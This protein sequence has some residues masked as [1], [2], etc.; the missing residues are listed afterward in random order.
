MSSRNQP[1][2]LKMTA[3]IAT[4]IGVAA[5][6]TLYLLGQNGPTSFV[7][8]D[9]LDNKYKVSIGSRIQCSC[10]PS[11]NDDCLHSIYVMTRIFSMPTDNPLVWQASYL[12]S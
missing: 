8:K 7:F 1:Y 10:Q 5:R 9:R 6:I 4:M 11:K 3:P 12:D 2:R